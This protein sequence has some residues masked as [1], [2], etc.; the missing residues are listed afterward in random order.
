M[1]S[2]RGRCGSC[3]FPVLLSKIYPPCDASAAH[4]HSSFTFAYTLCQLLIF[5]EPFTLLLDGFSLVLMRDD[6]D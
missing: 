1:G 4:C 6:S 3:L 5:V 2:G